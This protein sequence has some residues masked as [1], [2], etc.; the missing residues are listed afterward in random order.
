MF[1]VK[2]II[3]K[4]IVK[5]YFKWR[6]LKLENLHY[7]TIKSTYNKSCIL[8]NYIEFLFFKIDRKIYSI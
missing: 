7:S 8:N 4:L 3:I 5:V 1:K 6:L 2:I